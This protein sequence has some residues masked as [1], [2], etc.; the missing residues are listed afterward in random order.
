MVSIVIAAPGGGGD[1]K[2][3]IISQLRVSTKLADTAKQPAR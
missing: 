2:V 3:A 1:K